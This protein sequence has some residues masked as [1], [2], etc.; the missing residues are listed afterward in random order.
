VSRD[1]RLYWADILE[2]C[3][4][5]IRYTSGLDQVNFQKEEMVY[6]AIL[7][8]IALIGEAAGRIPE[9]ERAKALG[10]EWKRIIGARNIVVHAYHGLDGDIIWDIVSKRIPQLLAAMEAVKFDQ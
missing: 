6:D 2:S 10:I 9:G 5:I 8:N 7:R 3:R 1:W 4:K